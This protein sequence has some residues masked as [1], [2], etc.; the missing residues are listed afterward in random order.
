M[1]KEGQK[2]RFDPMHYVIGYCAEVVRGCG[3][4]QRGAPLVLCGVWQ[5]QAADEFPVR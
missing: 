1:V 3:H 4:G 5:S 2:V